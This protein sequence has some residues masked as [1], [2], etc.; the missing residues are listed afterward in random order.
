MATSRLRAQKL[1]MA[2]L[3]YSNAQKLEKPGSLVRHEIPLE[4]RGKEYPWVSRGGLKMEHGLAHFG[5]NVAGAICLDIGVSTGGFTDV[6]LAR[7]VSKVYAVD[8]GHGQLAW[9]LRQD[10]RV[11]VLEKTNARYLTFEHIPEP[12]S[13]LCCDASFIGLKVVL[14]ASMEFVSKG[15]FLIALIKPQFE[16]G[17]G[18]IGKRGVVNDPNL[19]TLVCGQIFDWVSARPGWSVIGITESP[20]TGPKGNKEFLIAACKD[21]QISVG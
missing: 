8:V 19:H 15:G 4:V 21:G 16:V 20:V 2:G 3:V 17:K 12:I 6:L 14:P 5:I 10:E 13:F 7:G 1:V 18:Q 11:I 9:K